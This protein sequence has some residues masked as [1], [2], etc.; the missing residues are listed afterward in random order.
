MKT[1]H[2]YS[3]LN[4]LK[5]KEISEIL[6]DHPFLFQELVYIFNSQTLPKLEELKGH[7]TRSEWSKASF[8]SHTLAS[9]CS[10]LGAIDLGNEYRA[11]EFSLKTLQKSNTPSVNELK[12]LEDSA[13]R[14]TDST[15]MAFKNFVAAFEKYYSGNSSSDAL[16][17]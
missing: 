8:L 9:S 12:G 4:H 3:Q 13:Q 7:I 1:T 10:N 6:S 17:K 5:L 11:L 14:L 16:G 2:S 15:K